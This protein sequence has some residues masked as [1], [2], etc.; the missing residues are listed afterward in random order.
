[1]TSLN[2]GIRQPELPWGT[3]AHDTPADVTRIM[4]EV[5]ALGANSISMDCLWVQLDPN[6]TAHGD[7][8]KYQWAVLDYAITAA[9]AAGL[10]I[11]L[12]IEP[13]RSELPT[14]VQASQALATD[15]GL[16]CGAIA[17][18]Y[19]GSR[20]RWIE[21]GNEINDV[22][23]FGSPKTPSKYLMFLRAANAN[24]K[25]HMPTVTVLAGALMAVGTGWP[26]MSPI[27]WVTAFYNCNP[28][29]DFDGLSMHHYM[30][31]ETFDVCLPSADNFSFKNI[32]AIWALMV[33]NGDGP[34]GNNKQIYLTEWG[35]DSMTSASGL[36]TT[37]A[38]L[39]AE[40]AANIAAQWALTEPYATAGI[41]YPTTWIFMY[42]DWEEANKKAQN[43]YG[44]VHFDYTP[45]PEK[46]VVAGFTGWPGTVTDTGIGSDSAT[47]DLHPSGLFVPAT[48]TGAGS[49]SATF[50]LVTSSA[51]VVSAGA[52]DIDATTDAGDV[53][54]TWTHAVTAEPNG[55]LIV[56]LVASSDHSKPWTL[57]NI[58]SV[59]SSVDG[60]LT[61]LGSIQ[62]ASTSNEK[63]TIHLFGLVDSVVG[64]VIIPKVPTAGTHTFTAEVKTTDGVTKFDSVGADS[65]LCKN[66][67]SF[68]TVYSFHSS[69]GG[70]TPDLVANSSPDNLVLFLFGGTRDFNHSL[71]GGTIQYHG[72]ATIT[73]GGNGGFILIA[74]APGALTVEVGI[75][76]SYITIHS[77]LAID[78]PHA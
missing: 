73:S 2:F 28:Q 60:A 30:R 41:I 76:P 57:Y 36:S 67:A 22:A 66:V 65:I 31:D 15:Y 16:L 38:E 33:A 72:G 62:I 24:I 47:F 64:G 54:I 74:T 59:S 50:D 21:I 56:G 4:Q 7:V 32:E 43:H 51:V 46:A 19:A 20:I 61:R 52:G 58:L 42:R 69:A 6:R 44:M 1:M 45:K 70:N 3:A 26:T 23:N 5:K 10:D 18:R 27:D 49:D 25:T 9:E 13:R 29:N 35:F 11:N 55:A 12:N 53:T 8:N 40:Q 71:F 48:D 63:G 75:P 39:E 77:A 34:T 14:G 37:D 68:G 17:Q 78:L